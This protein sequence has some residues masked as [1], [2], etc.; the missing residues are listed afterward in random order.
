MSGETIGLWRLGS[1]FV[2]I[3]LHRRGPEQVPASGFLLGLLVLVYVAASIVA[4]QIAQPLPRAVGMVIF[5]TALYVGYVWLV[6]GLFRHQGRFFQTTSALLGAETFL[7]LIGI[8]ILSLAGLENGEIETPNIGTWLF[9]LLILWSIDVA[10]FVLSRALQQSY[11]VGVLIVLVYAFGSFT[12]GGL[13][14]P[15]AS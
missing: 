4:T 10:G 12:L 1:V 13:V 11:V 5:D 6:L 3:A 7:T 14:F 9:F 8:P 15:V 2:D